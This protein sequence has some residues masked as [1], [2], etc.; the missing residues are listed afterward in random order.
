[1]RIIL[2]K[3]WRR[4]VLARGRGCCGQETVRVVACQPASR[5]RREKKDD[6]RL[7]DTMAVWIPWLAATW[8]GPPLRFVGWPCASCAM[9]CSTR[10]HRA[11]GI[12]PPHIAGRQAPPLFTRHLFSRESSSAVKAAAKRPPLHRGPILRLFV[13]ANPR[14]PSPCSASQP[15]SYRR[16]SAPLCTS[17]SASLPHHSALQPRISV[18]CHVI[19]APAAVPLRSSLLPSRALSSRL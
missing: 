3:M 13:R 12:S 5:S 19:S 1:M 4:C 16:L 18:C 9:R 14:R 7:T 11:P 8:G 6:G 17:E 15:T 10:A 2:S